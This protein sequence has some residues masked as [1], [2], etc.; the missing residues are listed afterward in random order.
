MVQGCTKNYFE[1]PS[2]YKQ[3]IKILYNVSQCISVAYG[4]QIMKL[5]VVGYI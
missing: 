1:G 5:S 3:D 4:L 2:G